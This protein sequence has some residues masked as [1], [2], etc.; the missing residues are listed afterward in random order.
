[1]YAKKQDFHNVKA[2]LKEMVARG[3]TPNV[4]L[5]NRV[6]QAYCTANHGE[7]ALKVLEDMKVA[8][9]SPGSLTF[10]HLIRHFAK[11][12][13]KDQVE[14]LL[15]GAQDSKGVQ[16]LASCCNACIDMHMKKGDFSDAEN[17][18]ATM[19]SGGI[20][21]DQGTYLTLISGYVKKNML[22]Q[23]KSKMAVMKSDFGRIESLT[24]VA[25]LNLCLECDT[26]EAV[27]GLVDCME[28][29][30]HWLHGLLVQLLTTP[31]DVC[32][33]DS[34]WTTIRE[35]LK[36][37]RVDKAEVVDIFIMSMVAFLSKMG[38]K[39]RAWQF[40]IESRSQLY[41]GGV[42]Y[43]TR[44]AWV[45]DLHFLNPVA[46]EVVLKAELSLLRKTFSESNFPVQ[47]HIITGWGRGR[48]N[49]SS[50]DSL[51]KEVARFSNKFSLPC[52]T[53]QKN[54]GMY[55]VSGQEVWRWLEEVRSN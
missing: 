27:R 48:G 44:D 5:F 28:L 21:P 20:T 13:K 14:A 47:I 8:E 22:E 11:Q 54:G 6:V 32:K 42:Q 3:L 9:V 34:F 41:L 2:I 40:W 55:I 38:L 52:H 53:L 31:Q 26:E 51:Q 10:T 4:I 30:G 7:E 1:M 25:L 24:Y 49:L 50:R 12:D 46:V 19:K 43:Q 29:S 36:K 39:K 16:L 35:E 15:Q 37:M 45:I 23:A 33:D 17:L 18:I